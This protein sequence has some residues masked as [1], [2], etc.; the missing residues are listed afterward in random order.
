MGGSYI[1]FVLALD[2]GIDIVLFVSF[3]FLVINV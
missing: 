2:I 1:S 3:V